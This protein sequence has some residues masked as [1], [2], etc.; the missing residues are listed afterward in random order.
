M[1]KKQ[2]Y[3]YIVGNT[4]GVLYTGMTSDL[5]ARLH[6]HMTG[7]TNAF[8]K[9]YR[10]TRLLFYEVFEHPIDA[11]KAEKIIKGWRR[12][13]KLDLIRTMNPEFKDLSRDWLDGE[14]SE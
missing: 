13:K 12:S 4:T 7:E 11:M 3:V 8:S 9:R 1:G 2:T 10:T 14:M 6:Q 5:A